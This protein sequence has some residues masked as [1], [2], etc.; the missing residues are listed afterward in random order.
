MK[1]GRKLCDAVYSTPV[2][3]GGRIFVGGARGD[4]GVLLCLNEPTGDI[5]W[6]WEGRAKTVPSRI[7]GWEIGIA[8]YPRELGVCSSPRW[9]AIA[10]TS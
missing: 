7:D 9:T 1:W 8:L 3:A 4:L 10:S 5:L 6:Q 2:I